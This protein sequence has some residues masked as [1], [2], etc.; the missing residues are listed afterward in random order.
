MARRAGMQVAEARQPPKSVSRQKRSTGLRTVT[1]H[2]GDTRPRN[3]RDWFVIRSF[4][5]PVKSRRFLGAHIRQELL[6]FFFRHNFA[7]EQVHLPLGVLGEPRIVRHHANG[8][9]LAV[10]ISQQLHHGFTVS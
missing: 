9:A 1:S 2:F 7:V 3:P 8:R 4:Y 10:K 5:R 6:E